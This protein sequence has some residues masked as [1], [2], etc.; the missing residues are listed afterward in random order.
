MTECRHHDTTIHCNDG[1]VLR[2]CR[3]CGILTDNLPEPDLGN[4]RSFAEIAADLDDI[5]G[6]KATQDRHNRAYAE[7]RG[8]REPE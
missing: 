4:T 2:F 6:L 1:R 5:F 3:N 8:W 7:A